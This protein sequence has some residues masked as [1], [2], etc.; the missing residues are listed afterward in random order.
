MLELAIWCLAVSVFFSLLWLLAVLIGYVFPHD[1][2]PL[3]DGE[4]VG[5]RLGKLHW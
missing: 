4:T 1:P 2:P 5:S 3:K